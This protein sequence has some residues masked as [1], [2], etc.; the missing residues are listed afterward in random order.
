MKL[1]FHQNYTTPEFP[2]EDFSSVSLKASIEKTRRDLEIAYAGF[3]NALETDLIDSY[4]YEINSLQ[5]RY[6]HLTDLASTESPSDTEEA[7]CQYSPIRALVSH[8]FG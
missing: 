1:I 7:L 6:K 2:E 3:D 8:V 5:K 4:I